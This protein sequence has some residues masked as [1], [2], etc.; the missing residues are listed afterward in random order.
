M[1][2]N[3]ETSNDLAQHSTADFQTCSRP[4]FVEYSYS[5]GSP[6]PQL[7]TIQVKVEVNGSF[8]DVGTPQVVNRT[9]TSTSS[10][11]VFRLDIS[12]L[13][14]G[15]LLTGFYNSIYGEQGTD[16]QSLI[17]ASGN[18]SYR[19]VIKY[20]TEARSWNL[21]DNILTQNLTDAP[22]E[23]PTS[24]SKYAV[25]IFLKDSY[26]QANKYS[27][28]NFDNLTTNFLPSNWKIGGVNSN[29]TTWGFLTNCP[30]S[31]V[32][33]VG[34]GQKSVL[35]WFV[36]SPSANVLARVFAKISF[37]NTSSSSFISDT[38]FAVTDFT[39]SN[40]DVTGSEKNMYTLNTSFNDDG[41]FD[42]LSSGNVTEQY[43]Q[44]DIEILFKT[45]TTPTVW[46]SKSLKFK[47]KKP[48][49]WT[50]AGNSN[51]Y[52]SDTLSDDAVSLYFI[53]DYNV[54]DFYT[55]EG[56]LSIT[57]EQNL[58]TFK[59]GYKDYTNRSSSKRGV[60]RGVTTEVYTVSTLVNRE[61]ADW[62][63]EIY[64][65]KEVYMYD[66]NRND[67]IPVIVIPE[68][69][70]IKSG[71]RLLAQPFYVSFVKDINVINS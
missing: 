48:R 14:K 1:A 26:V 42:G 19:T 53:N 65:S 25:D 40:Y 54:L 11:P 70:A 23:N 10:Q 15:Y 34:V 24:G 18:N 50:D 60:S 16:K 41:L 37:W 12:S 52:I 59:T 61:A 31:L 68:N 44:S 57:H 13:L 21:V 30:T 63:S 56:G 71:N 64:R 27:N 47:L 66:F 33:T 43:I 7:I 22:V 36:Y 32:R 29:A 2:H 39:G 51:I 17:N 5:S 4:L 3:I 49:A 20:K 45:I 9:S 69:I 46:K 6:I 35:N 55:F 8:I 38:E 67:F 28:L 62:L 58:T